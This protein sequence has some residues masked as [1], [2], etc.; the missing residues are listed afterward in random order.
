MGFRLTRTLF[1]SLVIASAATMIACGGR[2]SASPAAPSSASP[3]AAAPA[4]SA[5][6]TISGTVVG[7]SAPSGWTVHGAPLTVSVS[8]STMS[9]SVDSSGHFTLQ[10]VP[11]GHVDLHFTGS[12]VDAHLALDG[13]AD[14]STLTITVR[15]SGSSAQL[16]DDRQQNDDGH[17]ELEG[18]VTSVGSSSLVVAGRAVSVTSSTEIVHGDTHVALSSIHVNDRVHVKG[19]ATSGTAPVMATKIEVQNTADKP[20]DTNDDDHGDNNAGQAEVK[21]TIV[22]NSF[23]GSCSANSL[24]FKVGTTT[25]KTNQSTQFEDT[26][27]SGLKAGDAVEIE[28]TK[29]TDGSVL[30]AK[31][32]KDN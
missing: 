5:G 16:E 13:V 20:G 30:A 1:T 11:S 19:T 9:T 32:E 22:A 4:A 26:T 6:A 7:V 2:Q 23:G 25:I 10:N 17:V 8:G 18:L 31:V 12:G 28:G 24:F 27:C 21:G 29:Q 14:R 15:V 3:T